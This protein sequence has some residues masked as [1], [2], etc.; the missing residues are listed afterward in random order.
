[1]NIDRWTSGQH[2]D[3]WMGRWSRQ[4]AREF[5]N[6]LA[7]PAGLRWVDVCCGSGVVTEAIVERNAPSI[8]AGIDASSAQIS[9][10][11]EHRAYPNV[12][13]ETGDAMALPFADSSFDMAVC[14]LGLNF[15][16][17]PSRALEEFCRVTRAGGTIAVYVWDYSGGAVFLR[18]FWDTAAA[19]DAEAVNYDQA[20]RFQICTQEGLR[21]LFEQAKLE[22]VSLH[23]LDIV[24]SFSS[25]DNYWEPLLTGQGSAPN[26]LA[27]RNEATRTA[28]RERLRAAMPANAQGAIEM[29]ARAWAIRGQ[30]KISEKG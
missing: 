24:T 14:G 28:I 16:P 1:M 23:A 2:Y 3:E 21:T 20:T 26:Y 11:R 4:L 13:F 15:I 9:F 18:K 7:V 22:D 25:F 10:A 19:V 12:T 8:V 6:W 29:P 30:R 27:T 5:L 17:S